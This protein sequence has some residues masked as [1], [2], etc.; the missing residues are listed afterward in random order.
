MERRM[1]DPQVSGTLSLWIRWRFNMNSRD[2]YSQFSEFMAVM[3]Y[4]VATYP[5]LVNIE[6]L[7]LGEI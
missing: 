2:T 7:P 1:P 3:F 5:E 6:P 4:K